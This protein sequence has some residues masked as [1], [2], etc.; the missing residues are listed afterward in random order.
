[1]IDWD[2]LQAAYDSDGVYALQLEIGDRCYQDC[3]Y[4][5]MNALP[6]EKNKL[7]D[8]KITE[9]IGDAH[10][11]NVSAI[12]WLGGEPLLRESVFDHMRRA[13]DLGMRNNMWTGGL[14]LID[15]D[16]LKNTASLCRHGLIA[17]HMSTINPGV[18]QVLHPGRSRSDPELVLTAIR[19]LL[20]LGY[21]AD[22]LLNSVTFTGLQ[23][24]EDLIETIDFFE[25]EFGIKTSLNVYHTYVRPGLKRPDLERF[26]PDREAVKKVYE[27][28]ARQYGVEEFP[29]N[30]VNKQYCSATIAV[31]ADGSL[32][33]C[34]T[35]R[36]FGAPNVN[37]DGSLYDL[38]HAHRNHLIFAAFKEPVNLPE[39]CLGCELHQSCWGCRSRAF[40]EGRGIY[41]RDP[42][43]FRH[44]KGAT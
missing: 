29:M 16:V 36:E 9:I 2:K 40:A 43:C 12:E 3:V 26:I 14:P 41:G 27:R 37:N 7:S 1:M 20:D 35:I 33:P 42:R 13:S 6:K 38:F 25:R 44:E 39:D 10:R 4:C 5:Y 24:A 32:T 8:A 22:Q 11:L 18:Y 28:Y 17:V 15:V 19:R 23:S 21:P 34:A 31:L 30:C